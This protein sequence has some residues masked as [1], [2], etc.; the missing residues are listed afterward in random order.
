MKFLLQ[1]QETYIFNN[2]VH[3]INTRNKLKLHQP[4]CNLT[5]YQKGMYYMSIKIFNKLPD[6]IT[7]SIGNKR[8]FISRLNRYLVNKSL[9][10]IDEFMNN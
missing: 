2:E 4:M 6:H 3:N 8:S 10:S 1:N 5:L 7:D 9:Y